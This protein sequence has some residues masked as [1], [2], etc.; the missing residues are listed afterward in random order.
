MAGRSTSRAPDPGDPQRELVYRCE[1]RAL[2]GTRRFTR[3]AHVE[4]FVQEVVTDPWL[5]DDLPQR[6][7]VLPP[8]DV[9]LARRSRSATASLAEASR[10]VIYLRDGHW[11][12]AVVLHE[13]AHLA[14]RDPEPHGPV[15][16]GVL[17]DLVRRHACFHAWADLRAE[18]DRAGVRVAEPGDGSHR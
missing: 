17:C 9:V 16:C 6:W 3:F 4:Q 11:T 15:F 2:A 1:D 13:L 7:S 8:I 5:I 10:A 18:L 12:V 14:A